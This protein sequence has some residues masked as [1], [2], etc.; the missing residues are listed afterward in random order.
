MLTPTQLK[1]LRAEPLTGANKVLL[2]RRLT[3]T[4]QVAV[5][6]GIDG[7]I[8]AKISLI[9]RGEYSRLPLETSRKLAQF[10][11]CSIEDLFPARDAEAVAS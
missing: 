1:R 8:Q 9:E 7:M 2:A 11:G 10:F 3:G 4:S 5:A 6:A